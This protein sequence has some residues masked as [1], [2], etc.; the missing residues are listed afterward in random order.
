MPSRKPTLTEELLEMEKEFW[1]EQYFETWEKYLHEFDI[2]IRVGKIMFVIQMLALLMGMV[3]W[4][5]LGAVEAPRYVN[6]FVWG[7]VAWVT[8]RIVVH[9][10]MKNALEKKQQLARKMRE[11]LR[12]QA[13]TTNKRGNKYTVTAL[14]E[15]GETV[16]TKKRPS[17]KK[18]IT[19]KT[20]TT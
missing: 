4:W 15:K 5:K 13:K 9:T 19:G 2:N 17:R 11:Q 14:N 10:Q 18:V 1:K 3:L 7:G 16:A 6:F 20:T 8:V 12:A